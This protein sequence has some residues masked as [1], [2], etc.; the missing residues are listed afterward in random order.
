MVFCKDCKWVSGYGI[1][2]CKN[3]KSRTT[4]NTIEGGT[5]FPICNYERVGSMG[6]CGK[7]GK[8]W[9]PKYDKVVEGESYWWK[10]W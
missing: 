4:L 3:P 7:S 9:E 5:S 8:L 1:K 6:N 2:I 10:F